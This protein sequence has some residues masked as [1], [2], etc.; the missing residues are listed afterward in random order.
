MTLGGVSHL[1]F[2]VSD[3]D[4]SL[5]FYRDQLGMEVMSDREQRTAPSDMY[6]DPE[7]A[8]SRRV[9]HLR[10]ADDP[11]A[12]FLVLSSFPTASGGALR[13]D[14][15]GI[16]HVALW[17]RDLAA[18]AERLQAAGVRFVMAPTEVDARG[19]GGQ[20]GEAVLTCLFEDPDGIIVQFDERLHR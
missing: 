8:T 14:Q 9:A 1:A 13:L 4:R 5:A 7:R 10:W 15:I 3:M 17:V 18:K 16:H 20:K 11:D 12:P 2:G 6:A 19:Y